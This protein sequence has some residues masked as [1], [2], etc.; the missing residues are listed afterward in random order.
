MY[1]VL[2]V[3]WRG[4]LFPLSG[5]SDRAFCLRPGNALLKRTLWPRLFAL[6]HR[7]ILAFDRA[8]GA[9]HA[10]PR[11]SRELLL[12]LLLREGRPHEQRGC[13]ERKYNH[14][15]HVLPPWKSHLISNSNLGNPVPFE[16]STLQ[17]G[18]LVRSTST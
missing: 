15:F 18:S 3:A 17:R 1:S 16:F 11:C 8:G 14:G 13:N 6:R 2:L 10:K 5:T 7:L 4:S 9:F 12:L